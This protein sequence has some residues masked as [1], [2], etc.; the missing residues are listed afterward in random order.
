MWRSS[1][2]TGLHIKSADYIHYHLFDVNSCLFTKPLYVHVYNKTMCTNWTTEEADVVDNISFCCSISFTVWDMSGQGRYRNLWE[3]YYEWESIP[4]THHIY[5]H[6]YHLC[7]H[8]CTCSGVEAVV[9]V[10]DS[11]DKLRMPVAQEE[12]KTLLNH[13]SECFTLLR[14]IYIHVY[15]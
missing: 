8:V 1:N 14:S 5:V 7:V 11:S 2:M 15:T 13:S 3:H 4:C 6:Y 9:F 10:M 12:L